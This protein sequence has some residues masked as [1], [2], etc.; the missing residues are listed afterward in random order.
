MR[1]K[2]KCKKCGSEKVFSYEL[3]EKD[4]IY[5]RLVNDIDI[6]VEDSGI[7][8]KTFL[9]YYC[10]DCDSRTE[11][12]TGITDNLN[13]DEE[14]LLEVIENIEE[15]NFENKNKEEIVEFIENTIE[16]GLISILYKNNFNSDKFVKA[17]MSFYSLL[18]STRYSKDREDKEEIINDVIEVMGDMM[19]V[20]NISL[21][22]RGENPIFK[23][24]IK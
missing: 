11:I 5:F 2:F 24:V 22:S 17:L 9:N 10:L 4:A 1:L 19:R 3:R 12:F 8:R 23:E 14:R 20:L 7:E 15:Y 16:N 18:K 13:K 21:E 6:D